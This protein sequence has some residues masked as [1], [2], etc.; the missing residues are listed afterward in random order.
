MFEK[1]DLKHYC[2]LPIRVGAY[3][4]KIINRILTQVHLTVG[5]KT[6][7]T[8]VS[9]SYV[10]VTESLV[11]DPD[12]NPNNENRVLGEKERLYCARQRELSKGQLLPIKKQVGVFI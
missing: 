3:E 5:P 10:P 1:T 6:T 8:Q 7:Q 11:S 4:L 2:S 12:A 9:C